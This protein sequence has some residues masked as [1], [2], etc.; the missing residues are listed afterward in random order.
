LTWN[1]PNMPWDGC[2]L[3]VADVEG[4][5][6]LGKMTLVSGGLDESIVQPEWSP[7]G[8]LHFVSDKDG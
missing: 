8:V 4:D 5:G 7:D 3:W 2:E 1:H 6:S